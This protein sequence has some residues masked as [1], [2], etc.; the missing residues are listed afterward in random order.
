MTEPPPKRQF[1][2]QHPTD[3]TK[4]IAYGWEGPVG[5]FAILFVSGKIAA[6]RGSTETTRAEARH[7]LLQWAVELHFFTLADFDDATQALD[8]TRVDKLPRRLR[9]L[10]DVVMS[11]R[12]K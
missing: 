2:L 8:A 12:E 3:S 1:V 4:A 9:T 11:F 7:A 5:Y 6:S 10:V